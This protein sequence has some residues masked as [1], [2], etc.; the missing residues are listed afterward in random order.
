M[1]LSLAGVFPPIPTPFR[2]DEGLALDHLQRN[3]E[4]W[5][6]TGLTGYVVGGSN[7][8]F[9]YLS[10]EERLEVVRAA[11]A[12]IPRDRLL[13]AGSGMESNRQTIALSEGSAAPGRSSGWRRSPTSS[14]SRTAAGTS[15][16]SPGW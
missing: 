2:E 8:E 14:G 5:N 3:L 10:V 6:L 1:S 11:R 9:V 15:A 7:G 4:R 12:A 16:G 13:I